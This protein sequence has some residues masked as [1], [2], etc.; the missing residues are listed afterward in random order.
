MVI[1]G[2]YSDI[3]SGAKWIGTQGW[4]WVDRGGFDASNA[5]WKDR[6]KPAGRTAQ[7]ETLRIA[8]PL[9]EFPRLREIPQAHHHAGGNRP[10]LRHSRPSRVDFHADRPKDPVET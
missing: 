3:R 4:V 5:D 9:P 7:S 10:S 8:Q 2:G 6:Q 1:A